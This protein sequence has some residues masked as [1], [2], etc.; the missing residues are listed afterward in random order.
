MLL[1]PGQRLLRARLT[2]YAARAGVIGTCIACATQP[3]WTPIYTAVLCAALQAPGYLA[4]TLQRQT[5]AGRKRAIGAALCVLGAVFACIGAYVVAGAPAAA[6]HD[7]L[8]TNHRSGRLHR[9]RY[10]PLWWIPMFRSI[11]AFCSPLAAAV[12]L[13]LADRHLR[14]AGSLPTFGLQSRAEFTDVGDETTESSLRAL[15]AAVRQRGLP[16]N[17]SDHARD[18]LEMLAQGG[19]ATG[20]LRSEALRWVRH[21]AVDDERAFAGCGFSIGEDGRRIDED[22]DSGSDSNDDPDEDE[23]VLPEGE[24]GSP[25]RS[26]DYRRNAGHPEDEDEEATFGNLRLV[27]T[28]RRHATLCPPTR[29]RVCTVGLTRPF[30]VF[31][32]RRWPRACAT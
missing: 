4:A 15:G 32:Y 2:R 7:H 22:R 19:Q 31:F 3:T 11:V 16:Q 9:P 5:S 24:P 29:W 28:V 14:S 20:L 1:S 27:R 26:C 18:R 12:A 21:A 8:H 23:T 10:D 13:Q 6:D 17:V 25:L 30:F